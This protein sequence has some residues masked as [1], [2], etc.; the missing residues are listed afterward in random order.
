[1]VEGVGGAAR[2]MLK[3][4]GAGPADPFWDYIES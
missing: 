3:E 4:L 1:V 2:R